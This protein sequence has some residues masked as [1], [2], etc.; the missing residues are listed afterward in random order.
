MQLEPP[1]INADNIPKLSCSLNIKYAK[2]LQHIPQF[3]FQFLLQL[4]AKAT[5]E[6]ISFPHK[7]YVY[8]A[9]AYPG[10]KLI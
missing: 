3:K 7:T 1:K 6:L 4:K 2:C 5:P 8:F 9:F 10:G